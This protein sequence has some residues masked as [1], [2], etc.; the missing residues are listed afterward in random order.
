MNDLPA[1]PAAPAG[2]GA[3]QGEAFRPTR[4]VAVANQKGGV[5]KTTTV[6]N[7]A[8]C[9]AE[10]GK[11]VLVVDLDPQANATSGFGL[12][13]ESGASLYSVLLGQGAAVDLIK[14]TPVEGVEIIPSEVD[15]AGSEVD[16]A[17]MSG[18][19]HCFRNAIT[20]VAR[21]NSYDFI[22]V[23]CPPSLGILTMN[24]LTAADSMIVPM[25]CEYY[26]LEG[27]SVIH[28]LVDQL[29]SSGANTGLEIEGILMTMYDSRTNLSS[30]VVKEV[31]RHF[32]DRIY[33]TVIPRNVRLSEA[34]SFGQPVTMHD[35][36]SAGARAYKLLAEEFLERRSKPAEK[37]AAAVPQPGEVEVRSTK[38][39]GSGRVRL[40]IIRRVGEEAEPQ[41]P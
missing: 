12:D 14:P 30:Q 15:L 21:R 34:P 23:D 10:F 26:A 18:Y 1:D 4:T 41:S 3:S 33:R 39:D 37:P 11:R 32:P 17:R 6:I 35:P 38:E 9:L 19:L 28:R 27:L 8:A 31:N 40:F 13:R 36:S 25:Q 7:L 24:A 22:L 5:G 16:V 20:P 2:T 29:R